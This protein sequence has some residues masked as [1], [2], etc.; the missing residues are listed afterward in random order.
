VDLP[1]ECLQGLQVMALKDLD[2]VT[3]EDCN[4]QA[5]R[6]VFHHVHFFFASLYE[7][8][9]FKFQFDLPFRLG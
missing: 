9:A 5:P 4:H 6:Q 7:S 3:D 2:V 1:G 8:F